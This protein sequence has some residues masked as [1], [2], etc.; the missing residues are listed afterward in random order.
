M[1][2]HI[3]KKSELTHHEQLREQ[4]IF[5]ISTGELSIGSEMPSVRALSR[6]LGISLNTVSRV[7]SELVRA[8]WLSERHGAH[9]MVVERKDSRT[10]GQ[11]ATDLDDLI[12][13]A[14]NLAREHGYTLQQ[15]ATLLRQRLLEEPPDHFLVVAPDPGMGRLISEEIRQRIGYA[16]P[17][18][19]V[20]LLQQNPGIGIGSV[21]IAPTYVTETLGFIPPHRRRILPVVYTP[22]DY[23]IAKVSGLSQPSTVGLLSVSGAGMK[24]LAGMLAAAMGA[25]HSLHLF[26]MESASS[27]SNGEYELRRYRLD[28]YRPEDILRPPIVH[29]SSAPE[30]TS[31]MHEDLSNH[32]SVLA[33][34]LRCMDLLI[35]DSIAFSRI[36]HPNCVRYR[37]LS[38]QSLDRIADEA[39]LV[40]P[41]AQ[42]SDPISFS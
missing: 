35:C 22:V 38:E 31:L 29:T 12:D 32:S 34:D 21:L 37:L 4:I 9:H 3:N 10:E 23:I 42:G 25:E 26:L 11:P 39:K 27:Q 33:S 19:D 40:M 15:L 1:R 20:H 24:T 16:P 14:I 8:H 18:C 7:Y 36:H 41:S 28:E 30:A 13:R 5:L 6:Q 2:F 17:T